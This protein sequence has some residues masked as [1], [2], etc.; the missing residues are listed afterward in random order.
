MPIALVSLVDENRQRLKSAC[1]PSVTETPREVSF[2]GHAILNDKALVV[3][4]A[5]APLRWWSG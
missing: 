4:D 5:D 2:Y 1:G 3:E